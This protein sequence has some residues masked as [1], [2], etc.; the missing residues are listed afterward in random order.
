M[1]ILSTL[2]LL[3]I[4][5]IRQE[6]EANYKKNLSRS[7]DLFRVSLSSEEEHALIMAQVIATEPLF[8]SALQQNP[9]D[10]T[11]LLMRVQL[12][13]FGMFEFV[14]T[15]TQGIIIVDTANLSKKGT[16]IQDNNIFTGHESVLQ[17]TPI[18]GLFTRN[19]QVFAL[20]GT[21]VYHHGILIGT[22]FAYTQLNDMFNK[23]IKQ[24]TG[25]DNS[26]VSDNQRLLTTFNIKEIKPP[27][28]KKII[29]EIFQT[30]TGILKY[31]TVGDQ[32]IIMLYLPIS[33]FLETS[34]ED[35]WLE[36]GVP[37]TEL[38]QSIANA[39]RRGITTGIIAI[40]LGLFSAM[41]IAKTI[42]KPLKHLRNQVEQ[43][44]HGEY[45]PLTTI[46]PRDEMGYLSNAFNEMATSL[47]KR[48]EEL[49]ER[50]MELSNQKLEFEEVAL[51]AAQEQ[52]KLFTIMENV[53]DAIIAVDK[54]FSIIEWNKGAETLTGWT[55]D[56]VVGK[57]L[58]YY[59]Q[60]FEHSMGKETTAQPFLQSAFDS[61][62]SIDSS[63][64]DILIFRRNGT[65]IPV[66]I[67]VSP[68]LSQE[69][70]TKALV[71]IIRDISKQREIETMKEDFLATVT[72]DLA[73][74]LTVI[75]GNARI[76]QV[77]RQSSLS[78]DDQRLLENIIN[79]G[80]NLGALIRNILNTAKLEAGRMVYQ[81]EHF[82][83]S[84]FLAETVEPFGPLALQKDITLQLN[85]PT[86]LFAL[87]DKEKLQ[88]VVNNLMINA[89]K[90]T[91]PEGRIIVYAN[92]KDDKII[93]TVSD[94]GKGIPKEAIPSLFQKFTQVKGERR[95]TGLGLYIAKK[96]I[97][98]QNGTIDVSTSFGE[99]TTFTINIPLGDPNKAI[100][101]QSSKTSR[102][103][104][105]IL[106]VEDDEDIA[107]LIVLYLE[108]EYHTVERAYSA[109]EALILAGKNHYDVI[110]IDYNLPDINGNE[111][112]IALKGDPKLQSIP[113]ILI[114]GQRGM[115][116]VPRTFMLYNRIVTK[117]IQPEVLKNAIRE[118]LTLGF[119]QGPANTSTESEE[120]DAQQNAPDQ[121]PG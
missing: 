43:L 76:L 95:G 32:N 57:Y 65:K 23:R 54:N 6:K 10:T 71:A 81:I 62:K 36:I 47:R 20:G 112:A 13:P 42:N 58:N 82:S 25:T 67:A 103:S 110:T 96:F 46:N 68:I 78:Q 41:A 14:V 105:R 115:E 35:L 69:N 18:K 116:Y 33:D 51:L 114:T 86:D 9:H 2:T 66:H 24:L 97:E 89:L 87:G 19:K 52:E 16:N 53:P 27:F 5:S 117:P 40:I 100:D 104:G 22:C 77:Y 39:I 94:T 108:R 80:R 28:Q 44:K 102:Q 90:F 106:V 111:L 74:P 75:L 60:L 49:I 83:F 17:G 79:A 107:A 45:T 120:S 21:P 55:K 113:R 30:T 70:Y 1:A 26:I 64:K 99:G 63:L 29:E 3:E 4:S 101:E 72:H 34:F 61:Q 73:T 93:L 91:S 8:A 12:A 92:K 98:D 48:E 121:P 84:A 56:E 50:T 11:E 119:T 88:E 59:M 37:S 109:A 31:S 7:A 38:E 118:V 15:D 85:F